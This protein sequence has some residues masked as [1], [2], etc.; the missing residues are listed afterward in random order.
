VGSPSLSCPVCLA[1]LPLAGDEPAGAEVFCHY[2][3]APSRLTRPA[4]DEECEV[5]EDF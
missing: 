1:D 4:S 5:E 2:C 3:G